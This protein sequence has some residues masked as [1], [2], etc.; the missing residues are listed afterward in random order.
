[1]N[2]VLVRADYVKNPSKAGGLDAVVNMATAVEVWSGCDLYD[3]AVEWPR[4]YTQGKREGDPNDLMPLVGIISVLA[5]NVEPFCKA[6]RYYPH[7]WKGQMTKD[8]SEKRMWQK[9]VRDE[10]NVVRNASLRAKSL[11]HNMCDAVCIGLKHLGRFEP[12]RVIAR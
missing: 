10:G 6:T 11:S 9:L 5:S 3:L 7:E 8:V 2:D 12:H 1:V 4:V